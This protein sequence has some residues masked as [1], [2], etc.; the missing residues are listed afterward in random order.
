MNA[1]SITIDFGNRRGVVL[2]VGLEIG[3]LGPVDD[4]GQQ[5]L[6][7]LQST[8]P[9]IAFAYG[10]ISSLEALKRWPSSGA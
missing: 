8:T 7:S 2:V 6:G 5:S 9:S 3:V 10:S 4:V 1:S